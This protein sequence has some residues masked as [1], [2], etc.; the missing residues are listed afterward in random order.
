[1]IAKKQVP[2]DV[3]EDQIYSAEGIPYLKFFAIALG[4][5]F[6]G[7]IL[8]F[9][10]QKN[11]EKKV[12]TALSSNPT[13]PIQYEDLE[14][15]LFFP[16][17]KLTNSIIP[18]SCFQSRGA[19][20]GLDSIHFLL[21][22]ISFYPFGLKFDGIAFG[23]HMDLKSTLSLGLPN[24][25][26]KIHHSSVNMK[27]INT[28]VGRANL[29]KGKLTVEAQGELS[30]SLVQQMN[31][32]L[33][34]KNLSVPPQSINGLKLPSLNFGQAAGKIR[35]IDQNQLNL[36]EFVLGNENSPIVGKLNGQIRL[37][38]NNINGS[39]L[40]LTGQLKFAPDFIESFP[41]LNFFLNNKE[42]TE[43][44]FYRIQLTGLLGS[45]NIQ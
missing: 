36:D 32:V 31:M 35:L 5:F 12:I 44:G 10:L 16:K 2:P 1:M 30:G 37:N 40:D 9:S 22:G 33:Q 29:L 6:L 11:I 41:I 24:P 17:I 13:C 38:Q 4:M 19:S 7:L 23:D 26:F 27:F 42:K 25:M 28:I 20:I 21:S 45:P 3:L 18:G 43:D 8:N 15:G 39:Q 34:A 14:V